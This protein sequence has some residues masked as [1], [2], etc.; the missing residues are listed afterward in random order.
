[1]FFA[2]TFIKTIFF[3]TVIEVAVLLWLSGGFYMNL[4]VTRKSLVGKM[5]LC[6][7]A[8]LLLSALVGVDFYQSVWSNY[9]RMMGL[10]TLA[11]IFF[12]Y[13]LLVTVYLSGDEWKRLFYISTV[14]ASI[15]SI[16]GIGEAIAGPAS[17][18]IESTINNSAFLASY[19]LLSF[20]I[21]LRCF[22]ESFKI[23][24]SRILF[25]ISSFVIFTA[26]LLTGTRG[27]FLG[28]IFGVSCIVGLFIMFGPR[29]LKYKKMRTALVVGVVIV[30]GFIIFGLLA[31]K[32]TLVSSLG[33]LKRLTAISFTDKAFQGRILAWR[34][35][36]VGWKERP[37]FGWGV[38]NYNLLFNS[39][40]DQKL[41]DYEPW[42]DRAHNF[43]FD[44][45]STS[46]ILGLAAYVGMFVFGLLS[47]FRLKKVGKISFWTFATFSAAL[48]AHL[49]QNLLVF[50]AI[51][52]FIL[53]I[54][55]FAFIH[56]SEI[57][58][59][60]TKKNKIIPNKPLVVIIG[61][62]IFIPVFYI[63]VWGP[64]WENRIGKLGYDAFAE[65]GNF[66]KGEKLI[67]QALAYN[68][69]GNVDVRRSVAEYFF[70]FIKRGGQ[71]DKVGKKYMI[72]YA[73]QKMEENIKEKPMDVKWYMYQGQLYNIAASSLDENKK[74]Y[75]AKAEKRFLEAKNLSPNRLQIYLEIAQARKIQG[76]KEGVWEAIGWAEVLLPDNGLIHINALTHAVA[77]GELAREKAELP[78][79]TSAPIEQLYAIRDAYVGNG[80]FLEA[81]GVQK[82][83]IDSKE[84]DPLYDRKL[85]A[86]EYKNLA[87]FY[88]ESGNIKDARNAALR[89]IDLDPTRRAA[90]E[91]F[92]R[93]LGE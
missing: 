2:S 89:V 57:D 51:S 90:A 23:R 31:Q 34:V 82:L 20:F 74:E 19:L 77:L 81:A 70:E 73:A 43:I 54:L 46:G 66:N 88:K 6:F 25:G 5:V 64:F 33:P 75:A 91:A 76:N 83:A 11:H 26:M 37:F 36:L 93:S 49:V 79:L 85:L 61:C 41:I 62:V 1:V 9:E 52:S 67:E 87:V 12:F 65:E 14:S 44:I 4:G 13:L 30:F 47:L 24:T 15:V 22:T 29:D 39:H 69:Y 55:I 92:L 18:R 86:E 27:A 35:S 68:T 84:K 38:E 3:L 42:F 71:V 7:F 50:D 80:R 59:T 40:Y 56:A 58:S 78:W 16:I 17:I 72:D 32:T 10:W 48:G 21:S 28:W 8:I 53:L 63:G 45:G 60:H